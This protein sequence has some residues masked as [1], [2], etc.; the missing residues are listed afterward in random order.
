MSDTKEYLLN[1]SVMQKLADADAALADVVMGAMFTGSEDLDEIMNTVAPA[2]L[3][4][5]QF[6][7]DA[8]KAGLAE[9]VMDRS[10]LGALEEEGSNV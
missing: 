5:F 9:R 4:I 8:V 7:H 2:G 1:E 6:Q 10:D 3:A